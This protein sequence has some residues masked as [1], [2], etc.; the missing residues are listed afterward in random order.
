MSL[1]RFVDPAEGSIIV[2]G[3]DITTIGL[4]DLRSRLVCF[5]VLHINCAAEFRSQTFIPQDSVLFSGTI[6]YV[7]ATRMHR[8]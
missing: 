8:H 6:R 1:L 3:I 4:H 2:D 7:V 5:V